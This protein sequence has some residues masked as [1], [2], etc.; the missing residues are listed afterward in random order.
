MKWVYAVLILAV[1]TFCTAE[2][3]GDLSKTNLGKRY[4]T[5]NGLLPTLNSGVKPGDLS[6]L[7]KSI[8]S[9]RSFLDV[10]SFS[11]PNSTNTFIQLRKDL[12]KLFTEIGKFD[13]L[14]FVK[15]K[16]SDYVRLLDGCI[17]DKE[18]YLSNSN[19][20]KYDEYITLPSAGTLYYRNRKELSKDF[21]G[22]I[23]FVPLYNNS[24]YQN[25]ALLGR[26]IVSNLISGYG[27]FVNLTDIWEK[28]NHDKFHDYRKLLRSFIFVANNFNNI[29]KNRPQLGTLSDAYTN[30]GKLNDLI[31]KYNYDKDP[32]IKKLII[33]SQISLISWLSRNNFLPSVITLKKDLI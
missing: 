19:I 9:L 3:Y 18:N 1:I 31:N 13:D 7:R 33:S 22:D 20:Y 16:Q 12:N 27:P 14:R 29:F 28:E 21:W 2:T 6:S 8:I 26:G 10:F 23:N 25:L 11:Y 17:R 24:G 30:I 32:S 4:N 15:Y 5:F